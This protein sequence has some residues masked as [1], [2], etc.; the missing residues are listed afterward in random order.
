[1]ATLRERLDQDGERIENIEG[2]VAENAA[3]A[4]STDDV[5]VHPYVISH[6]NRKWHLAC[7]SLMR[8]TC[9]WQSTERM[10]TSARDMSISVGE[11]VCKVCMP[12]LA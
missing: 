4:L 10:A 1:M 8:T 5:D 9:G 7:V 6:S 12:H 2:Q 3:C 11:A